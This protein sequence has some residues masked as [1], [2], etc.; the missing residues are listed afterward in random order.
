ML[1]IVIDAK[2]L[3]AGV[4]IFAI[5]SGT[6]WLTLLNALAILT[7]SR[8]AIAG[9]TIG[10]RDSHTYAVLEGVGVGAKIVVAAAS[11]GV[12][13]NTD[14]LNWIARPV[15]FALLTASAMSRVFLCAVSE[16]D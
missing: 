1:A 4:A 11:G 16:E 12:V 9:L 3:G 14:L 6:F 10:N 2:V 7:G 15:V 13:G 8:R 5:D